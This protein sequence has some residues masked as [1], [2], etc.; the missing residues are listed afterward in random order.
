MIKDSPKEAS[1]SVKA[2]IQ[3]SVGSDPW[4]YR[5]TIFSLATTEQCLQQWHIGMG[6]AGIFS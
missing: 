2:R 3:A 1:K 5:P 6:C 4:L